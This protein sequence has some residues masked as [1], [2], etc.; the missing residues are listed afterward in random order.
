MVPTRPLGRNGPPV[1]AIGFGA[2]SLGGVYATEKQSDADKV[3]VLQRAWEIGERFWDTADIYIDAEDR[4][5]D[6]FR[7]S[8]KRA[9]IF[10]CTKFGI[11]FEPEKWQIDFESDPEYIRAACERSLK[12]LG[13]DYIDLYYL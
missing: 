7:Q 12:R 3:A 4:I 8:G 5:G 11:K 10:L 6:W 9:D 1:Q 2:M 13:T